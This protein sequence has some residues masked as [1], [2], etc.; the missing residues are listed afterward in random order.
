MDDVNYVSWSRRIIDSDV[1]RDVLWL[2]SDSFKL[3]NMCSIVLIM[4]NTYKTNK[5]RLSLLEMVGM[6]SI[7]L[8]FAVV[9]SNIESKRA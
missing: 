2:H 4:D 8:T 9:F 3:L 6:A 1:M 7:E 5:Y